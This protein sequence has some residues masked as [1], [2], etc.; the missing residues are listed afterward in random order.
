M[1]TRIAWEASDRRR[2]R[3]RPPACQS[4]MLSLWDPRE[5]RV[6]PPIDLWARD[7][8]IDDMNRY[9]YQAIPSSM[10]DTYQRATRQFRQI[11]R[12]IHEFGAGSAGTSAW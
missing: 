5:R 4:M 6:S 2:R 1:P 7:T 11:A 9:F 3:D 10:A 8:T 12:L